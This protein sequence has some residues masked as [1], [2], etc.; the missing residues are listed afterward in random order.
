[1]ITAEKLKSL[2]RKFNLKGYSDPNSKY[3][4]NNKNGKVLHLQ[5]DNFSYEDEYYGGE[6]YSGNETIWEDNKPIF[7]CVYW[8]KVA[9]G[10]DFPTIYNFLRKALEYGPDK[11]LVH[12]GP[13]EFTQKDFK[14]SNT[15]KGDITEF[16]QTEKIYRK[17]KEVYVAYFIGGRVSVNN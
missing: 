14:Y 17:N 6:P 15:I 11:N 8:G 5:I 4:D 10:E 1:M 2:L 16:K 12:R 13:L 3:L 7:R 9:K